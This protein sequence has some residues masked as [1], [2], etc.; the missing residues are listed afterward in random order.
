MNEY[1][2]LM[3]NKTDEGTFVHQVITN[4]VIFQ[5]DLETNKKYICFEVDNPIKVLQQPICEIK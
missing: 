2:L 3:K 5:E 4:N 1:V